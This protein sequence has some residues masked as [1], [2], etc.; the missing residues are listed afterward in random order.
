MVPV[1]IKRIIIKYNVCIHIINKTGY[2]AADLYDIVEDC[3]EV[4]QCVVVYG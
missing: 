1:V 2:T 3:F 4:R